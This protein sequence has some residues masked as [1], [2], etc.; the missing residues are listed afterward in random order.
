MRVQQPSSAEYLYPLSLDQIS[1]IA[2]KYFGK[3]KR[4]RRSFYSREM[5]LK[6]GIGIAVL[7][8]VILG[9]GWLA[10]PHVLDW[11][12]HT[13][14]TVVRDRDL[15]A[16]SAVSESASSGAQSTAASEPAASSVPEKEPEPEVKGTDIEILLKESGLI[17]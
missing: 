4:Y 1:G 12:T 15:S 11:A 14:Y 10:A 17:G 9:V 5:K 16:S 2:S 13:W 8:L 7:V 3:V 6:K